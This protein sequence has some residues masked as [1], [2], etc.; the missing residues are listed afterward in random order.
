MIEGMLD[1][2]CGP[3]AVKAGTRWLERHWYHPSWPVIAAKAIAAAP[4]T[5]VA[6]RLAHKL[7]SLIR[8]E[9]LRSCYHKVE[10]ILQSVLAEGGD[11]AHLNKLEAT[12]LSRPRDLHAAL[13]RLAK[14][15]ESAE[16]MPATVTNVGPK[17]VWVSLDGVRARME[18]VDGIQAAR[19]QKIQVKVARVDMARRHVTV[20]PVAGACEPV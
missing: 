3:A 11:T 2:G 6:E 15:A 8:R 5:P 19:G 13:Q 17:G 1:L 16:A 20:R 18:R 10:S 9:P 12:L 14:C 7:V 4:A